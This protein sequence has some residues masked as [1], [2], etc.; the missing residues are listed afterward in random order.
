MFRRACIE[1]ITGG[2]R[3]GKS[4]TGLSRLKQESFARGR[5][6][7]IFQPLGTD[8]ALKLDN[9]KTIPTKGKIVGRDGA[10][11]SN[12]VIEIPK[13]D[14]R[15]ILDHITP[16]VTTVLIDE[17]HFFS[18]ELVAVAKELAEKFK[19]RVIICGL[20][21]TFE[22]EPFGCMPKLLCEADFVTKLFA[23][24]MHC[25]DAPGTKSWLHPEL[26][27]KVK[28][29][30]EHIGDEDYQSVCRICFR[31]LENDPPKI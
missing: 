17:A 5:K 4:T 13:N 14:P 20:D 8:R 29:G 7:K 3:A 23:V 19:L 24:C 6:A 22:E 9:G 18:D 2:M 28:E 25:G 31:A 30:S 12:N 15:Q 11:Q 10:L 27:T 21:Q 26:R 1:V 16:E